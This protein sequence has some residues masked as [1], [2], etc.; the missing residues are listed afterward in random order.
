MDDTAYKRVYALF[1]AARRTSLTMEGVYALFDAARRT[2]LTMEGV[3]ALWLAASP[4]VEVRHLGV[5]P[6]G[7]LFLFEFPLSLFQALY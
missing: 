3:Y 7:G 6:C 1:D 4:L 5:S 2:S